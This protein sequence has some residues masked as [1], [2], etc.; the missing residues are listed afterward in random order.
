ME[1][2]TDE[3]MDRQIDGQNRRKLYTPL[4]YF[5]SRGHNYSI[6]AVELDTNSAD[7]DQLASEEAN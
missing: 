4:A 3:R 6:Q 7:S 2:R 1:G 5:V